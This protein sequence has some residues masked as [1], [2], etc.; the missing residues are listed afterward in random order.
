M[1]AADASERYPACDNT[2]YIQKF[3]LVLYIIYSVYSVCYIYMYI[4]SVCYVY[5]ILSV[6]RIH[7]NSCL[8][9]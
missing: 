5:N 6:Y 9:W 7:I 2:L 1:S 3:W 4:N 8:F